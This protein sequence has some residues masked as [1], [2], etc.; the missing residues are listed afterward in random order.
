VDEL[1][2]LFDGAHD[3]NRVKCMALRACQQE[4]K[5]KRGLI[6]LIEKPRL[7]LS[8]TEIAETNSEVVQTQRREH[9]ALLRSE[10]LTLTVLI[11]MAFLCVRPLLEEWGL[12][13]AFKLEGLG[14]VWMAFSHTMRP[15]HLLPYGLQW[16]LGGS[17][18]KFGVA[19]TAA[20][21]LLARYYAAR[22][23]I[24]PFLN[25]Y[26]RWVISTMAATLVPWQGI[27]LGRYTPAQL[28]TVFFFVSL[29]AVIRLYNQRS[30]I[31]TLVCALCVFMLLATYQGLFLCFTVVP[32][33]ILLWREKGQAVSATT[34]KLIRACFAMSL[35]G[36]FY[37]LYWLVIFRVFG[38]AMY[39]ETLASDAGSLL[40]VAGALEHIKAAFVTGYLLNS[41]VLPLL[42]GITFLLCCEGFQR[43]E[44]RVN[45]WHVFL[46]ILLGLAFLPFLSLIYVSILHLHDPERVQYPLSVGAVLLNLSLLIHFSTRQSG[47][48]AR[49]NASAIVLVLVISTSL[50]A[51]NVRRDG[52]LEENV[53]EQTSAV[54]KEYKPKSLIIQDM[55][56]TLGDVYTLYQ[57]TL[58]D[59][60]VVVE[61]DDV[62]ATIC[63][64]LSVD[65]LHPVADR[66]PIAST[67]RCEDLP[68]FKAKA[69]S[70]LLLTQWNNGTLRVDV[71]K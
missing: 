70:G 24:T 42:A 40:T 36:V 66:F 55:T 69:A 7:N 43:I 11:V 67:P 16:I 9:L 30:I 15:M 31:W 26:G 49:S 52:V 39:E 13:R 60:L 65:R 59:A 4:S 64:P 29:G 45:R 25:G 63:T 37:G 10:V 18:H 46:L 22:W 20:I 48:V 3:L 61:G 53:L 33:A 27:W 50:T 34:W 54:L 41:V 68:E 6:I 12:F 38:S 21:L 35:G 2:A 23:A 44:K 47:D 32:L 51:L 58:H 71:S 57:T 28:S 1:K 5:V 19:A 17:E 8:A 14:Y 56:G 62:P